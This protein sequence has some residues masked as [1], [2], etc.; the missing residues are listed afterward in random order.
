MQG[1]EVSTAMTQTEL[2]ELIELFCSWKSIEELEI[3]RSGFLEPPMHVKL[4]RSPNNTTVSQPKNDSTIL[5]EQSN[6]SAST[7]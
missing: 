4:R 2:K 1:P 5:G 7:E 6:E 3:E